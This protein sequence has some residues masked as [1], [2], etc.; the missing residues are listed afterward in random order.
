MIS[1]R[2]VVIGTQLHMEE[3]SVGGGAVD[4]V[5]LASFRCVQ[6]RRSG[7]L[8]AGDRAYSAVKIPLDVERRLRTALE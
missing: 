8:A 5:E 6:N 2:P 4:R 1:M 7:R 3:V